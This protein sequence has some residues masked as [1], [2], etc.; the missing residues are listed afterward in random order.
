MAASEQKST[1]PPSKAVRV[2]DGSLIRKRKTT[3]HKQKFLSEH[4]GTTNAL[5]SV[6]FL[7]LEEDEKPPYA[8]IPYRK[9]VSGRL[10]GMTN[11][12]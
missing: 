2:F 7:P 8:R 10:S 5:S 12:L 3:P 9:M 11:K 4:P 6:S 1:A